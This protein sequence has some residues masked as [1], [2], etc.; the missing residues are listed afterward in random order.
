M[1]GAKGAHEL[2]IVEMLGEV[3]RERDVELVRMLFAECGDVGA[4]ESPIGDA[5]RVAPALGRPRERFGKVDADI[6]ANPGRR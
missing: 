5:V 4:F 2:V 3:E 6:L 1:D